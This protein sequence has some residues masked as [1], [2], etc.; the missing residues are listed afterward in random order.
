[1]Y[2]QFPYGM[3]FFGI[4][5]L[6][7]VAGFMYIFYSISKSLKRMAD[8]LDSIGEDVEKMKACITDAD[9]S[10]LTEEAKTE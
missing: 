9:K 1:M 10:E 6:G 3:M 8:R 7:I 5:Y 4:F 2:H